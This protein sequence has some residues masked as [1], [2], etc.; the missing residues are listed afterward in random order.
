MNWEDPEVDRRGLAVA[1]DDTVLAITSAG[2]NALCL[3]LE[4]PRR[5]ICVDANPAQTAL[6]ELKLAAIA[7]L[8]H[9]SFF[10]IFG[11]R[12]PARIHDV[13]GSSLRPLLSSA[14]RRFWDRNVA[15]VAKNIYRQG[16]MGCFMRVLQ[17]YLKWVGLDESVLHRFLDSASLEEQRVQ[18]ERHIAPRLWSSYALR[19]FF[20]RPMMYLAGMHPKQLSDL[21]R[22]APLNEIVRERVEHLLLDMPLQNNYFVSIAATGVFRDERRVPPWLLFENFAKLKAYLGR[23]ELHTGRLED[24]LVSMPDRSISKY[25]LLDIFDWMTPSEFE[26]CFGSI[27]RTAAPRARL[28]YRSTVPVLEPPIAVA[29]H[30]CVEREL[31]RALLQQERSGT[32][33]SVY[34]LARVDV[35][36]STVSSIEAMP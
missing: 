13:Y 21:A 6:F 31:S 36:P 8:D 30:F 24:V 25:N 27:A 7:S 32:H 23:I 2:C 10:D 16:K 19:L 20:S 28:I 33:G 15:L 9:G 4:S 17:S 35:S 1:K 22:V 14:A 12:H 29:R 3:L 18:Y 34:V 26:A 11:A 5:L